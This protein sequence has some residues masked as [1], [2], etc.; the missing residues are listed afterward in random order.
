MGDVVHKII[1]WGCLV[2]LVGYM[3]ADNVVRPPE[4]FSLAQVP[5][6]YSNL[7]RDERRVFDDERKKE[8]RDVVQCILGEQKNLEEPVDTSALTND[9][10]RYLLH[11]YDDPLFVNKFITLS[12]KDATIRD[13]IELIGKSIGLNFLIDPDVKGVIQELSFKNVPLA[14]ALRHILQGNLPRLVLV[15][16]CGMFRITRLKPARHIVFDQHENNFEYAILELA[17]LALDEE[18]KK[19]L[20]KMWKAII[21]DYA[22]KQGFYLVIDEE[23]KKVFAEGSKSM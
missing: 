18:H 23:S 20:E 19:Q 14:I 2:G 3:L 5:P 21:G 11:Q 17:H 10:R 4:H 8:I 22:G 7:S 16:D 6:F 13:A 9:M 15:K 12:L 1:F